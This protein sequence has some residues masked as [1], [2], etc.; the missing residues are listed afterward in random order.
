[1]GEEENRRSPDKNGCRPAPLASYIFLHP[2]MRFLTS[3]LLLSAYLLL[4]CLVVMLIWR[5]RVNRRQERPPFPD[6]LLRA[7]GETLRRKL[8]DFD[9]ALGATL[10]GNALFPVIVLAAG[11]SAVALLPSRASWLIPLTL[12]LAIAALVICSRRLMRVLE[13]RRNHYLGYFGERYA[14]EFIEQLRARGCRV[15][16]DVP[17]GEKNSPFNIDHVVAGRT[18]VFAIETKTRRKGRAAP[19]RADYKITFDGHRIIYPWGADAHGLAQARDRALWLEHHLQ[20]LLGAHRLRVTPVL[21]FPGWLV[22][23]TNAAP[24][25]SPVCVLNPKQIP[26]HIETQPASLTEAQV[27]LIARQLE[28]RCRDVEF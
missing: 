16:H 3:P 28:A 27:D 11:Y 24:L 18:G 20:T 4:Y 10:L 21:T 6:K 15:F 1:M 19:G 23:Q 25:E 2:A 5:W 12:V 22:T 13:Q 26:Q 17:A 8:D 9:T 7:P 14:G